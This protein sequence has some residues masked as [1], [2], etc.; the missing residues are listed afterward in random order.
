MRRCIR[1]SSTVL[2]KRFFIGLVLAALVIGSVSPATAGFFG[3]TEFA[4]PNA[5]QTWAFGINAKGHI[6]GMYYDPNTAGG[7]HGYLLRRG[8]FTALNVPGLCCTMAFGINDHDQI[9]GQVGAQGFLLTGDDY[10]PIIVPFAG[11]TGTKAEG[12]NNLGR[13]VGSYSDFTGSHGFL[14]D[15]DLYSAIDVPFGGASDT[16]ATGIN[17]KGEIVGYFTRNGRTEGF[18]LSSG[19]YTAIDAPS[20][21]GTLPLPTQAFGINNFGMVVGIYSDGSIGHGFLLFDGVFMLPIDVPLSGGTQA[22]IYGINNA[23]A[24]VATNG[25]SK[26]FLIV[27]KLGRLAEVQE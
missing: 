7:Y 18:L 6:V 14:F 23:G 25:G 3:F 17:D 9:V 19:I 15:G 16:V 10:Q 5:A 11:A 22:A 12:I 13:I 21:A 26:A 8:E 2:P 27:P 20:Q 1:L 24:M 4:F